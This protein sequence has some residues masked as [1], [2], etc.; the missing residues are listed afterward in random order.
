MPAACVGT[1]VQKARTVGVVVP[2]NGANST[3]IWAKDGTYY[4]SICEDHGSGGTSQHSNDTHNQD[5]T[6]SSSE[7]VGHGNGG[8]RQ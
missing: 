8:T 2:A 5:G 4:S 7:H 3:A 6:C 1:S